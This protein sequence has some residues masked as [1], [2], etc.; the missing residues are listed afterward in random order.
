MEDKL[1][2]SSECFVLVLDPIA[3]KGPREATV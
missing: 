1:A 2:L 3:E